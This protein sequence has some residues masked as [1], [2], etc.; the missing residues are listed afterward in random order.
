MTVQMM[1][2]TIPISPV[3]AASDQPTDLD[4]MNLLA[5][6]DSFA[7]R[8]LMR[9]HQQ[10]VGRIA[11]RM[12]SNASSAED[13]VQETFLRLFRNASR[14]KPQASLKT[15]L[16]RIVVN[17]AIDLRRSAKPVVNPA[18]DS[19]EPV[20]PPHPDPLVAQERKDRVQKAVQMLPAR[21]RAAL[22]LHRFEN[23][24]YREIAE[25][26]EISESAVESLLMRAYSALRQTLADLCEN[27]PKDS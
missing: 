22:T 9:R 3:P 6:G 20:A 26:L 19:P 4:L 23:L 15:Y 13:L 25:T 11:F 21:Q 2:N 5:K 8:E 7:M 16:R 18:D 17:L 14:Y 24:S 1:E 12:T 10:W 27:I